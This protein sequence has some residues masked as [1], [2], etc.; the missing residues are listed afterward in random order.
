MKRLYVSPEGRG[1]GLGEGLV[2]AVVKEAKRIGYRRDE[3]GHPP[4][5]G[6]GHRA[7]SKIRVRAHRALLREPAIGTIFMRR[8]HRVLRATGPR[9]P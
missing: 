8:S 6:R 7:V 4:L 2:N 9:P 3:A 5:D 1:F